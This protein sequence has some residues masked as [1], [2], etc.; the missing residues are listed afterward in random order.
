MSYVVYLVEM[1]ENGT[2]LDDSQL[3]DH[4]NDRE[5]AVN[6]LRDITRWGIDELGIWREATETATLEVRET[7]TGMV[8]YSQ[9][10]AF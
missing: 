8:Y 10:M 9:V 5:E 7:Q 4:R 3:S 6:L 1:D 2:I